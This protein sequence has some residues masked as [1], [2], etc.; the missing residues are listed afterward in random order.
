MILE[1]WNKLSQE[2]IIENIN[3]GKLLLNLH[4]EKFNLNDPNRYKEQISIYASDSYQRSMKNLWIDA[5]IPIPDY[6]SEAL[7]ESLQEKKLKDLEKLL[8]KHPN[9]MDV[10]M[11]VIRLKKQFAGKNIGKPKRKKKR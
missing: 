7:K 2:E 5:M 8:L 6:F 11:E 1:G 3:Y 10:K 4:H 9:R